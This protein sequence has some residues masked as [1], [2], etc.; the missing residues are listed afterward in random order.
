M[1]NFL[2]YF[3]IIN[4][5]KSLQFFVLKTNKFTILTRKVYVQPQG[6]RM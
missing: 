5:N 3:F 4:N 6:F 1:L 2:K